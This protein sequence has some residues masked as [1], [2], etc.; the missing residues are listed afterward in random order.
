M[1]FCYSV[2]KLT[3]MEWLLKQWEI[4]PVCRDF[5]GN[6]DTI[7][8]YWSVLSLLFLPCQEKELRR[9]QAEILKHQ[10]GIPNNFLSLKCVSTAKSIF[11]TLLVYKCA[12][13]FVGVYLCIYVWNISNVINYQIAFYLYSWLF[14]LIKTSAYWFWILFLFLNILPTLSARSW[15]GID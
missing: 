4:Q 5:L 2:V 13:V 14:S 12:G 8:M 15:R 6:I 9:Q 11:Q 1:S 3:T 10:V 7:E